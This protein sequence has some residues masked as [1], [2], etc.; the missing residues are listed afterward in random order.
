MECVQPFLYTW[1]K[2]LS[3]HIEDHKLGHK[4]IGL[5]EVSICQQYD[6]TWQFDNLL[7]YIE[8]LSSKE[9]TQCWNGSNNRS[10]SLAINTC[11]VFTFWILLT[12]LNL[13]FK[14]CAQF[15]KA[16][17]ENHRSSSHHI[18]K[19]YYCSYFKILNDLFF[20]IRVL[21]IFI[22]I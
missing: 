11:T 16:Y 2:F 21:G 4:P 7:P 6:P 17:R 10:K 12:F 20:T 3:V 22:E 9:P 18:E 13:I 15:K 14:F 5:W 8:F 19:Q 1:T